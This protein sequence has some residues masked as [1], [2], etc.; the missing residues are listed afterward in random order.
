MSSIRSGRSQNLESLISDLR[1]RVQETDSDLLPL[2]DIYAGE[3]RFGDSLIATD[4]NALSAGSRILEIGAGVLLLSCHLQREGY[5]V[6]AVEPVGIGFSH[7]DRLR[8]IVLNYAAERGFAPALY[9]LPAEDMKFISE[10]DYAFSIN[11]MEHVKDVALV[12]RHVFAAIKQGGRHRFLCPN[13]LFPYEPHFNMPTFFSKALTER[14]LRK[15]IHSSPSVVDSE[16][17]WASLNWI[18]VCQVRRI[19]RKEVG[20]EPAF[21]RS[22]AYC[23]VQRALHDHDFQRR[24]GPMITGALR[25]LDR[26]GLTRLLLIM[27]VACQPAMDCVIVRT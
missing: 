3:A 10:F 2:F 26:S 12:L 7:F 21:N 27:P 9:N 5:S 14:F 18:S 1:Q 22:L 13:Y 23:F 17:T 4:I 11:V 25:A 19:C 16:G 24:R 20:V 6:T 8:Q 15:Y